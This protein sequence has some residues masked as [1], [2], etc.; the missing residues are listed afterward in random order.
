M[1]AAQVILKPSANSKVLIIHHST[2]NKRET[3][4][5][6]LVFFQLWPGFY[7]NYNAVPDWPR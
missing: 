7:V 2:Q 3:I 5:T 6:L 4:L 1:N